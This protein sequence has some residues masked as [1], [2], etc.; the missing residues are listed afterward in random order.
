MSGMRGCF[1]SLDE[2]SRSGL[3]YLRSLTRSRQFRNEIHGDPY[4]EAFTRRFN[5]ERT[6]LPRAA[7]KSEG[8][9]LCDIR[10]IGARIRHP[11]SRFHESDST[12]AIPKPVAHCNPRDSQVVNLLSAVQGIFSYRKHIRVDHFYLFNKNQKVSATYYADTCC[13]R[14]KRVNERHWKLAFFFSR[15]N[16]IKN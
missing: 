7:A 2:F 13:I 1:R 9:L 11:P 8:R 4:T 5:P 6:V 14:L 16:K 3:P 10:T 12:V 15:I